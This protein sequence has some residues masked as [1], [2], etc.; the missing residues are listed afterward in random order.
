MSGTVSFAYILMPKENSHF[1]DDGMM[2]YYNFM[3][4]FIFNSEK[5]KLKRD[6]IQQY[7]AFIN[8]FSIV[9]FQVCNRLWWNGRRIKQKKNDPISR[10]QRTSESRLN[11]ALKIQHLQHTCNV[12]VKS[13]L[14][15]F[16]IDILNMLKRKINV[17]FRI[18]FKDTALKYN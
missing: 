11:F 2:Q 13:S 16:F 12:F 8:A 5:H 7:N 6:F 17:S 15:V 1:Y 14:P 18:Y 10:F 3:K 4:R 9:I